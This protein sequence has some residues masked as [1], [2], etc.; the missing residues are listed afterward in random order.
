[1]FQT[2]HK[3]L[4][5]L[6]DAFAESRYQHLDLKQNHDEKMQINHWQAEHYPH[7]DHRQAFKLVPYTVPSTKLKQINMSDIEVPSIV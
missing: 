5:I 6:Y 7:H 1:M 4:Q 2:V 3:I